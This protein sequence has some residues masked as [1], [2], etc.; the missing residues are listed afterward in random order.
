MLRQLAAHSDDVTALALLPSGLIASGSLDT[1]I[2]IW[3]I[4]KTYP[5]YILT[6]HKDSVRALIVMNEQY[7]ASCS[8]DKTIKLWSLSSYSILKSWTASTTKVLS[9]AFDPSLNALASGDYP[10]TNLVKV[11]DMRIWA[12]ITTEGISYRIMSLHGLKFYTRCFAMLFSLFITIKRIPSLHFLL[13]TF[14]CFN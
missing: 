9:L 6:G 4:T 1:T 12:D 13:Y 8:N 5:L 11:W 14:Y 7:L 3:D 10:A 2:K